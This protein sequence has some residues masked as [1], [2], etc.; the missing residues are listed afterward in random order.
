MPI[1]KI[2]TDV[3]NDSAITAA[4][5][6][7][8]TVIASDIADGAVTSAKLNS[9]VDLSGKTVTYRSIVAGDIADGAV[10]SAKLNSTVDLSGKTVTYRS[11]VAGDIASD[12]I[13]NAKIASGVDASKL[14]TGT[15]PKTQLSAGSVV[16]IFQ[17]VPRSYYAYNQV[18]GN[19]EDMTAFD[20]TVS[21]SSRANYFLIDVNLS[22][23]M[24]SQG[25]CGIEIYENSSG[26]YT[27]IQDT[28]GTTYFNTNWSSIAPSAM[29]YILLWYGQ[30]GTLN[31]ENQASLCGKYLVKLA[32]TSGS[33][34]FNFRL[35][36]VMG[37]TPPLYVN[38]QA[39]N[40]TANFWS[41]PSLSSVTA[42]EIKV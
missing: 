10:T 9:T 4:K 37:E 33:S 6:A 19:S 22:V 34:A 3:L 41:G 24:Q 23:S 25:N 18:A 32:S 30:T 21:P 8:G 12:A 42:M 5:I 2:T 28:S 15:L 13:T 11:I 14:T 27:R 16:N 1:Q 31:N 39:S 40:T 17:T 7:D 26:S 36:M 35:R 29:Q 38:F 20:L